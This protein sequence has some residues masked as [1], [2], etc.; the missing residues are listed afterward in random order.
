M[1]PLPMQ[2]PHIFQFQ[3]FIIMI[4]KSFIL[5]GFTAAYR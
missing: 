3:H 5:W 2:S 4:V 1:P